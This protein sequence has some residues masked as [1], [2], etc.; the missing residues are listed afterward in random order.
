MDLIIQIAAAEFAFRGRGP[1]RVQAFFH[2]ERGWLDNGGLAGH[3]E[4]IHS[5]VKTE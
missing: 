5:A 1:R 3:S 2:L 4:A